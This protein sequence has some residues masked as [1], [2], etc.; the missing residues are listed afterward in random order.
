M[1]P[2]HLYL[3]CTACQWLVSP[4]SVV[5]VILSWDYAQASMKVFVLTPDAALLAALS[6]FLSLAW[7]ST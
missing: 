3:G 4:A 6:A 2:V 1:R 7:L 5:C